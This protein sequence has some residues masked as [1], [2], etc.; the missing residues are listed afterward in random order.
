MFLILHENVGSIE[1]CDLAILTM[2]PSLWYL[3]TYIM[4]FVFANVYVCKLGYRTWQGVT[5]SCRTSWFRGRRGNEETT[6]D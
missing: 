6:G 5:D 4:I 1:I 3:G 2:V